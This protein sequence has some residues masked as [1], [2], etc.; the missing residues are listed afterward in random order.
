MALVILAGAAA[1]D[2]LMSNQQLPLKTPL[3]TSNNLYSR[4]RKGELETNQPGILMLLDA[5]GK[6]TPE[7]A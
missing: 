5:G 3:R 2:P 7:S 6:N 4:A 1:M